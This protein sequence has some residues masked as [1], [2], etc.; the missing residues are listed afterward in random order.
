MDQPARQD[1]P[2]PPPQPTL[3]PPSG[4][5][6]AARRPVAV[7]LTRRV[8]GQRLLLAKLPQVQAAAAAAR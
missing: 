2:P 1:P 7:D 6:R 4:S 5:R 3:S 8:G